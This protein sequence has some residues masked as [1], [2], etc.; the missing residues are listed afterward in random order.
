MRYEAEDV[1]PRLGDILESFDE[2]CE[3]QM[4][5][6]AGSQISDPASLSTFTY[7]A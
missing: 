3:A 6:G 2:S 4:S 1:A 5:H 7:L